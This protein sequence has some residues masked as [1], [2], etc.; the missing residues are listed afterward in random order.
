MSYCGTCKTDP[1]LVDGGE[2][3]CHDL[4]RWGQ[5]SG[6]APVRKE[7]F[8]AFNAMMEAERYKRDEPSRKAIEQLKKVQE[9]FK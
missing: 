2:A 3:C 7:Q 6:H 9:F 4:V 5:C 8:D 1:C